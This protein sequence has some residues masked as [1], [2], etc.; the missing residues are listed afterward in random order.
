M[1]YND[2]IYTKQLPDNHHGFL[3]KKT[4]NSIDTY[5]LPAVSN[6]IG[7]TQTWLCF[8]FA[9]IIRCPLACVANLKIFFPINVF[10]LRNQALTFIIVNILQQWDKFII[11]SPLL[12]LGSLKIKIC[13]GCH[14]YV[15]FIG[16]C[17]ELIN[18]FSA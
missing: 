2:P 8:V 10:V 4:K 5:I 3:H 13:I 11:S 16:I 17:C 9:F 12:E 18:V 7:S 14:I 1:P 6:G 15:A